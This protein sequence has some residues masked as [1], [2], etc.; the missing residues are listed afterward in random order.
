MAEP[1]TSAGGGVSDEVGARSTALDC[2]GKVEW[3]T[4]VWAVI[5]YGW[6]K[7]RAKA[8]WAT[9]LRAAAIVGLGF[10]G[11]IYAFVCLWGLTVDLIC[12]VNG[13]AD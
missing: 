10:I 11:T 1:P 5:V 9:P 6:E 4:Q 13:P 7:S 3:V 12:L 8:T 2:P